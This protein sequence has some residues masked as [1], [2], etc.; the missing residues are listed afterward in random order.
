MKKAL[1]V[2]ILN[3]LF[4]YGCA[5]T[6]NHVDEPNISGIISERAMTDESME[7]NQLLLKETEG[8]S[9]KQK[10]MIL[11]KFM[12]A[13]QAESSS[14]VESEDTTVDKAMTVNDISLKEIDNLS[15]NQLLVIIDNYKESRKAGEQN[16]FKVT[17]DRNSKSMYSYDDFD[18][19]LPYRKNVE[20]SEELSKGVSVS[21]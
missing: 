1:I 9:Q 5:A 8:L 18:L 21:K 16:T 3:V 11:F 17:F 2:T 19:I 15:E 6:N 13:K 20:S 4:C 10:S 14:K 7:L 12:Q